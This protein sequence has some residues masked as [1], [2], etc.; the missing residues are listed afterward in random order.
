MRKKVVHIT[1]NQYIAGIINHKNTY[2]MHDLKANFQ[3]FYEITKSTLAKEL[4]VD[5]NLESYR[6][7]PTM[8]D[9]TIISL[10]LCSE[11]LGIDSENYL[12]SKL[13]S[14]YADF[15]QLSHRTNYNR[16]R[17][18]LIYYIQKL[19]EKIANEMNQ[20]EDVFIVDSIPVPVCKIVRE[21]RCKICLEDYE[22]SPDKGYTAS[23]EKWVYGYKL[24]LVTSFK[25]VFKK[26]A[27]TKASIH[28]VHYLNELKYDPTL[29]FSTIIAD[30]GY[31]SSPM[32]LELF[33][34]NRIILATPMRRG[35]RNY[36]TFPLVFKKTRRRI[37]TLF[38]Q[39]CD[40]MMFK[41]NYAKSFNGLATR[42]TSKIAAVTILQHINYQ[43]GKP[44]N[45]LK[46]ALAA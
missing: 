30:R 16:R 1:E 6:R 31:L 19:T 34:N 5:G 46:H 21:K 44:L 27:L 23:L 2:K 10:S 41:R 17:K 35:Q 32:Q 13:Q 40:Q 45:H 33:Q 15:F 36:Q 9:C 8:N 22:T 7:K 12:W 39:L 28:D 37:E 25:G 24:Q 4:N 20:G 29:A 43:N 14:E 38:S 42:I 3:K 18:R 26:M 11:A